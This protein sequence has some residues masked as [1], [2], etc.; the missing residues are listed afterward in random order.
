MKKV[1]EYMRPSFSLLF[2][3]VTIK[4]I[5]AL[6][7][8][9]LPWVLSHIIDEVVPLNSMKLIALWGGVMFL[10][11]LTA[12]IT[13]IIANRMAAKVAR[14]TTERLRH[15]LFSKILYLSS[16]QIDEMT[17]PSLELRLTS[18]T[19]HVHRMI[20]M[21]QRMGIRAPIL[22]IGGI[23]ITLTLDPVLTAVLICTLPFISLLVLTVTRKGFPMYKQLQSKTD[24]MVRVVRENIAGVRVIKALSKTEHEKTRFHTANQEVIKMEKTAGYTM[25]L[26]SPIMNLLLNTGLTLVILVGAYRVNAGTT[27]PGKI[28]AFMSYFTIILNAM[29][30][31]TRIFVMYSRGSASA[32]RIEEVLNMPVE[33]TPVEKENVNEEEHIVFD[34]VNFSYQKKENN[35]TDISFKLKRGETLG[36]LGPTGSGKSTI[37]NLLL[38]L[39]DVD[40]GEIRI[41]G[42]PVQSLTPEELHTKFGIVFQNDFVVAES[43]RENIAFGRSLTDEQIEAASQNAQAF[44]FISGLDDKFDHQVAARGNNLSGGQKQRLLIARAL[45]DHPEV[46][47]LDDSSSALDYK[48]DANLRKVLNEKYSDITTIIIAQRISS[49]MHADHIIILED[50]EILGQGK[51]QELLESCDLYRM[52]SENQMGGEVHAA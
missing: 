37:I 16:S 17:L 1:I 33:L 38:R 44:E 20:T 8:L 15:E 36:I 40:S 19:Y 48:T 49:L 28:L 43:I 4:F 29:M 12:L 2:L 32:S 22:L 24:Y 23:A 11:A 47:I 21:M 35:L 45:A 14:N 25:S 41:S 27:E 9:F 7:D 52:I 39:Y 6:M 42:K 26:T 5:G 31:V 18:D 34:H 50:G 3:G 51:H 13:N 10:C 46:L 30:A